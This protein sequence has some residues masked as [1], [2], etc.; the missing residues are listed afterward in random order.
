MRIKSVIKAALV[1]LFI[2]VVLIGCHQ[3]YLTLTYVP[4]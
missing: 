1:G 3:W 2:S 4:V